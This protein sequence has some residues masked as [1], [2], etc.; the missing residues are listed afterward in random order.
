MKK[1]DEGLGV[2]VERPI[3]ETKYRE[4]IQAILNGADERLLYDLYTYAKQKQYKSADYHV[5]NSDYGDMIIEMVGE[6]KNEGTLEYLYTFLQLFI[7]K[8]G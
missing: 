3:K 4:E 6:I 7:E 8:W 5:S 2:G 1:E